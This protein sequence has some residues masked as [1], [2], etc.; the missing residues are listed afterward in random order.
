[1]LMFSANMAQV[2]GTCRVLFVAP[3]S[4]LAN[5]AQIVGTLRVLSC[6]HHAAPFVHHVLPLKRRKCQPL[7]SVEGLCANYLS[8]TAQPM[9]PRESLA[10]K[11]AFYL[12]QQLED[13]YNAFQPQFDAQQNKQHDHHQHGLCADKLSPSSK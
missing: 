4:D 1:M 5:I 12:C 2:V 6:F 7:V 3:P 11:N 10:R 13:P 8:H 9:L